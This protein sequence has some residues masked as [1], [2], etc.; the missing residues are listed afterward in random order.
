MAMT[1]PRNAGIPT[2]PP[3]VTIGDVPVDRVSMKDAVHW[4]MQAMQDCNRL[5]PLLIMGPNAQLVTLAEENPRLG[6][7]LRNAHLNVPDGIS[8][9]LGSRLLGLPIRERVP[10][11]EL[12]EALCGESAGHGF[13]VFF[14]GGLPGAATGAAARLR[15]RYPA[16]RVAGCYCPPPGFENDEV[17][18]AKIRS[19]IAEAAPDLLCVAFGAPKQEIW[20]DENC[21]TLPIRA[22][23]SVGAA[24]D[25]CAGLRKRAPRWTHKIGL[26]W[27]Y[28]LILEP[29]RLWRRYLVGNSLFL[30]LVS[31]QWAR[32]ACAQLFTAG[33]SKLVEITRERR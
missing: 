9:V 10:G 11:G 19:V 33:S 4:V 8:V 18:S 29:R 15:R 32:Q 23:I 14:L 27:L 1:R 30:V 2:Q 22:A 6:Q 17:E 12:M 26:E 7:A 24:L 3:R 25:T 16:L 28:R 20:M 5:S 31:R 21:P 13:G